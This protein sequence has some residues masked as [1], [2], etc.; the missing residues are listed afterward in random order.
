[1]DAEE[2]CSGLAVKVAK[3]DAPRGDDGAGRAQRQLLE[4]IVGCERRNVER[5][6]RLG[7]EAGRR[8]NGGRWVHVSTMP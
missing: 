2:V 7:G 6:P 5:Q 4:A 1:M 8:R 3:D